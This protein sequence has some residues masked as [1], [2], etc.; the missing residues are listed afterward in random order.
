MSTWDGARVWV[1]HMI[2]DLT[3]F[4]MSET[5]LCVTVDYASSVCGQRPKQGSLILADKTDRDYKLPPHTETPHTSP[6]P[7]SFS[8]V[9]S[10]SLC[11]FS[12]WMLACH[13]WF[14]FSFVLLFYCS[15]CW[16]DNK[17]VNLEKLASI[18]S[19]IAVSLTVV[20]LF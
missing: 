12:H 16:G 14:V 1:H 18:F 19:D 10:L 2:L 4:K 3:Y 5:E 8:P 9:I 13:V 6:V 17:Y 15:Q 11:S 20:F 7:F